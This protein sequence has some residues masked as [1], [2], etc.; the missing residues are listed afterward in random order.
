MRAADFHYQV[1]QVAG[2]EN[3]LGQ[4][5]L[6][7]PNPFGV[8]MHGTSNPKLFLSDTREVSHG[9]VRVEKIAALAS[10]ALGAD[11]TGLYAGEGDVD[12]DV[13]IAI[14][15]GDTEH[16][17]L[18]DPLPVYMLYW[19]AIAAPDG[20]AGFRPDR[21]HRDPPLLAQLKEPR[22]ADNASDTSIP[23]Q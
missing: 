4:L 19:T 12:P 20:T 6:D 9:C 2:P 7:A 18:T 8:Y 11:E 16:L 3:A 17:A 10:L 15:S 1:Q 14:A 5:M 23:T 22:T 13:D 21:Y